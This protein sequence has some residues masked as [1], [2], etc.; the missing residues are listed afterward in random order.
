MKN[1]DNKRPAFDA[2]ES[3]CIRSF[4]VNLKRRTDRRTHIIE[5]FKSRNEFQVNLVEAFQ[6]PVGAIGVWKTI[7]HILKKLVESKDEYIILC[8]DDHLF[9]K[10]YS[11]ELLLCC[12]DEATLLGAD[13]LSCGVSGFT[14]AINVSENLYWVEKFSDYN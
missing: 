12:I 11:K 2:T 3:K 10:E 6:H 13:L 14:S 5:Q 7:R 1:L 8:Q 9:T 4:V